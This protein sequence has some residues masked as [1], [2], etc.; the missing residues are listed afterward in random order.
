MAAV[1]AVVVL[2]V[3]ACLP[4]LVITLMTPVHVVGHVGF[5]VAVVRVPFRRE[6]VVVVGAHAANLYPLGV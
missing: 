6:L 3:A 1:L 2:G 5:G 4:R